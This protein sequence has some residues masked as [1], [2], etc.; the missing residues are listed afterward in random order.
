MTVQDQ[1]LS[2]S[3]KL[4]RFLEEEGYQD[5]RVINGK[6]Y[7]LH[8]M[9]FTVAVMCNLDYIGPREG[10]I[11]FEDLCTARAFLKNWDGITPPI[12]GED[13]CTADKRGDRGI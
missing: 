6:M 4:R 8:Y 9:L 3:E 1:Q 11:C 5:L 2:E 13:G 10:R 12:V 7:G